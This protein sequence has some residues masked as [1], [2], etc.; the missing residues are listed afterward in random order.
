MKNYQLFWEFNDQVINDQDKN[1]KIKAR[2]YISEQCMKNIEYQFFF[3]P[4]FPAFF[5]LNTGAK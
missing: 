4:G 1:I 3:P 5:S 2:K